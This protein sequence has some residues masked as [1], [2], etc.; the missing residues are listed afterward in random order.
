MLDSD[1]PAPGGDDPRLTIDGRLVVAF[2][3]DEASATALR[4][5]LTALGEGLDVRRGGLRQAVKFF[6]SLAPVHAAIIDMSDAPDASSGDLQSAL[7]ELA[8][9]CPPEVP[10]F[11][12]GDSSDIG[13]YRMVVHEM[14]AADY[15]PRPLTRDTV[16]RQLLPRL[17]GTT[18]ELPDARGGRVIAFCGT[19]GG[20]G[21]TTIAVNAALLVAGMP[22]SVAVGQ[23]AL[24]DLHVQDGSAAMMLGARPS[25]GLRLAL[26]DPARSDALFLERSAIAVDP[27]LHLVAADETSEPA[28][29]LKQEGVAHVLDVLRRRFNFVFV[30]LPVPIPH[31]L[32]LVLRVARHVVIVVQPDLPS[33]RDAQ[34]IRQAATLAAGSDRTTVVLNRADMRGALKRDLVL[35]GL[36]REPDV[37]VPDLGGRMVEAV[38]I[39]TPALT[40]VPALRRH[41]Q[42]LVG[43]IIGLPATGERSLLRRIL[44]R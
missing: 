10:V 33:L 8:R 19:R 30:D 43:E 42:P 36:G 32:R 15:F 3:E 5:G 6:R 21:A 38:N 2:V 16:Q 41:L 14:G 12:I 34:A 25:A 20:V 22:Q 27:R 35:R 18:P 13:F 29:P 4:T 40:H 31:E 11:L 28:A 7:D 17:L 1:H 24:L 23:S 39:G 37:T 44:R 26:E 9:T